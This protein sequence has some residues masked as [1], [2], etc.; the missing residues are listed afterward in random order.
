LWC[1]GGHLHEDCPEKR[2]TASTPTCCNC[3][4]AEGESAPPTKYRGLQA[5]QRRN[6]KNKIPRNTE[7]HDGK[8]VLIEISKSKRALCNSCPRANGSKDTPGGSH[9]FKGS[10]TSKTHTTGTRSASSGPIESSENVNMYKV[11]TVVQQIMTELNDAVS[12]RIKTFDITSIVF[13]LM[14]QNVQ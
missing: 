7:K 10:R 2:N 12:E 4:L 6:A 5:C 9:K 1:E 14:K 11:F 8:G 13:S 3:Q